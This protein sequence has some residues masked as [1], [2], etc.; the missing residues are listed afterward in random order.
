MFPNVPIFVFGLGEVEL[1]DVGDQV[2][3]EL[4][5]GEV[6]VRCT[7]LGTVSNGKE[8]G[9]ACKLMTAIADE[10]RALE[11]ERLDAWVTRRE[12]RYP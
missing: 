3:V 7:W 6:A 11:Q 8:L 12:R 1:P 2:D 9:R 4:P 5:I 10:L